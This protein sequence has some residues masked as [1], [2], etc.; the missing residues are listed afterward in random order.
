[1]SNTNNTH[2][3]ATLS[4]WMLSTPPRARFTHVAMGPNPNDLITAFEFE[5]GREKEMIAWFRQFADAQEAD[6]KRLH[7]AAHKQQLP[8]EI[9]SSK[10]QPSKDPL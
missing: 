4:R 5:T 3:T 6:M 9:I 10:P 2:P 1:M 8:L 7:D